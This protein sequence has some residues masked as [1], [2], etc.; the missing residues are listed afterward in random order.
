MHSMDLN[1]LVALDALLEEES[2][3]LAAKRMH[4]SP[5]A[6]SRTLA[7][8]REAVGDPIL[9]RAGR[10]LVPTL[11]QVA[12]SG[13][14]I[15]LIEQFTTVALALATTAGVLVRGRLRLVDDAEALRENPHRVHE[16]YLAGHAS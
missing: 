8:V 15:L 3:L 2:V 16:A 7:R 4:L 13:V 14:G 1:L 11:A 9:V 6:M 5:S 12:A 10:R